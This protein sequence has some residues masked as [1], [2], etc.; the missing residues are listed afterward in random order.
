MTAD[1]LDVLKAR[2]G[3]VCA[4]GAGG[5][6][7]TLYRL[8]AAHPGRTALTASVTTVPVPPQY[9]DQEFI[10]P[11]AEL[12]DL[13]ARAPG[14]RIFYAQPID[15]P[16]RLGGV[17]LSLIEAI[18]A[19]GAFDATYV[20]ADGARM[21]LIKAPGED[22]PQ[23][24]P[25]AAT[26]LPVVSA[27]VVGMPFTEKIAHRTERLRAVTGAAVGQVF[28]PEHVA[29]LLASPDGSLG[30]VGDAA[31]VPI[32]NMVDNAA[33]LVAARA[34]ARAALNLTRR[35]DR[36]VLAQMTAAEPVVEVAG[37]KRYAERD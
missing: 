7:T 23:I 10:A 32:I 4:T 34:A 14:P 16:E 3:I 31:V 12:A 18:H 8:A 35:F 36:V 24:P 6:K 37:P 5:K 2:S 22:E 30:G 33:V 29:R 27:R 26:V 17:P 15:K 9:R 1:L 25:H 19:A 11:A 20:K 28:T 21:R 13:A